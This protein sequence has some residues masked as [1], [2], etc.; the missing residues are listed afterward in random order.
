MAVAEWVKHWAKGHNVNLWDD[1]PGKP[2][3]Y[4]CE[5]CGTTWDKK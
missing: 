2:P 4:K 1:V 3:Y 5:D